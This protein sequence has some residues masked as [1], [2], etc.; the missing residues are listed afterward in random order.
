[1][2]KNQHPTKHFTQP[3]NEYIKENNP[4]EEEL[5]IIKYIKNGFMN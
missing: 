5:K 3:I 2:S 1:M 4:S